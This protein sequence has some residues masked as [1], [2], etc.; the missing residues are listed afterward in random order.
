MDNHQQLQFEQVL[1]AAVD[2]AKKY[3]YHPNRFVGMIKS[4]GPFQTVKD[5]VASGSPSDGFD[6]LVLFNRID[7]TCEAIIVETSWRQFFD[8]DLLEIA[9]RRLTKYGYAWKRF[10]NSESAAED[11][12]TVS[13]ELDD[14]DPPNDDHRERELRMAYHRPQ[15]PQFREALIRAYGARCC[16]TGASVVEALEAAH[17]SAYRGERSNHL[18]NGLLLRA[19]LHNLFDRFMF[20]VHPDSLTV[21]LSA[22]L[23]DEPSYKQ[24]EGQKLR[25]NAARIR[26]SRRALEV[27]WE[28]FQRA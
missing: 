22:C 10:D 11:D 21:K 27:H 14:F 5:I 1:L 20:G 12:S 23:R 17:I 9:Q 26:P 16:V 8:E 25:I 3:D 6:K 4:K 24:L 2:Q 13:S 7:L 19:D 28:E 18:Q 15:Q